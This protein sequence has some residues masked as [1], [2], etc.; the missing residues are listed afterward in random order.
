M[1]ELLEEREVDDGSDWVVSGTDM[2]V[3]EGIEVDKVVGDRG[4]GVKE[5]VSC[6]EDVWR[7]RDR[8]RRV[9]R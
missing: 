5:V 9:V 6:A 3:E 4:V 7:T 2:G 8:K 1:D